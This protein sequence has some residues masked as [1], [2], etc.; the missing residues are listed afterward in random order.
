[1]NNQQVS[2]LQGLKDT[3]HALKPGV[4]VTLQVQREGRLT[5]VS[6]TLE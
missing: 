5:Y 1:V 4:A 3:M 6:F 2:T